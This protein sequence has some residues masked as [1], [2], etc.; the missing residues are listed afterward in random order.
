MKNFKE[1]LTSRKF[2]VAVAGIVSGVLLILGGSDTEG[3][4][5]I[6]AS[7]LGYLAAE[8][9]VDF[10]AIKSQIESENSCNKPEKTI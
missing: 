10:A 2:L 8:G 1:K 9:L 4:T 7:A 6:V 5:A 3:I